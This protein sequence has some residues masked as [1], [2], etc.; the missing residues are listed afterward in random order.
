M[1]VVIN[2]KYFV[3]YSVTD[4]GGKAVTGVLFMLLIIIKNINHV[5]TD[6]ICKPITDVAD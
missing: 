5:F 1:T 4:Y 2:Y 3:I 6:F